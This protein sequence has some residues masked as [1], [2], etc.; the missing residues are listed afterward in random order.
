[1]VRD[2]I[3][4]GVVGRCPL[5]V[6]AGRGGGASGGSPQRNGSPEVPRPRRVARVLSPHETPA[7]HARVGVGEASGP[8]SGNASSRCKRSSDRRRARPSRRRRPA[9]TSRRCRSAIAAFGAGHRVAVDRCDVLLT[10]Q[11]Q[12]RA[13]DAKER[14]A[15]TVVPEQWVRVL[16]KWHHR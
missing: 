4:C 5:G 11:D 12:S 8:V 9:A 1:M 3:W 15:T 16:S 7:G 10:L 2:S 6:A 13:A 14:R